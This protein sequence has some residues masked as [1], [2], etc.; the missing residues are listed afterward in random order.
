MTILFM[1]SD[2]TRIIDH[3]NS[4]NNHIDIIAP[5]RLELKPNQTAKFVTDFE[6]EMGDDEVGLIQPIH[7]LGE[8]FITLI[9]ST[10]AHSNYKGDL[11]LVITNKGHDLMEINAGEPMGQLVILKSGVLTLGHK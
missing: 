11:T 3:T 6:V 4:S 7:T 9:T 5:K 10:V 1:K 2:S 8:R